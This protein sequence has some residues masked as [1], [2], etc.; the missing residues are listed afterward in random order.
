LLEPFDL[1]LN[2]YGVPNADGV[3]KNRWRQVDG[4]KHI[5]DDLL[6][7]DHINYNIESLYNDKVVVE[8]YKVTKIEIL[9]VKK[10]D[11]LPIFA[12]KTE[13]IGPDTMFGMTPFDQGYVNN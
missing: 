11:V 12:Y 6:S 8:K 7:N 1:R 4:V 5:Y 13:P 2:C 9:H 10:R 3:V